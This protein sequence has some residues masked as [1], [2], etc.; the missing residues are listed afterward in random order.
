MRNGSLRKKT[1]W[2][3]S[4]YIFILPWLCGFFLLTLFPM[5]RSLYY[6]FTN[7]NLMDSPHWAGL[8]NYIKIFTN[9]S[10]F[11]QSLTITLRFVAFA[12]PVKL[13]SALLVAMLLKKN[14]RGISVYRTLLYL[15]TL[16]GSSVASAILWRHIWGASGLINQF[17]NLFGVAGKSWIST[18]GTALMTLIVQGIWQF[19]SSMVIFL[20]ALKQVPEDLYE[21]SEIDGASKI[22]QFFAIT[23][24]MISPI[25]QFNLILQ[26]IGAFQMFTQALIITKGGPVHMTFVYSL[27]LY[28]TAFTRF[29][30]GY[31][32]A[33]AWI[34]LM[35]ITLITVAIFAISR[36]V[37]FYE[38]E[39]EA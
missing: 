9:D 4:G 25:I 27:Y 34:L 10:T 38:T 33:L 39:V 22:R 12:V 20:S 29:N 16:I 31:A 5:L 37:V 17:L 8:D 23:L 3:W 30:L 26:M 18:P 24:P 2:E 35:L 1:K 14:V 28:E 13:V 32:S 15:P 7:Y 11:R 6:S 21:A 19:G 36:R